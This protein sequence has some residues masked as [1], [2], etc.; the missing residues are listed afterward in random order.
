MPR[1]EATFQRLPPLGVGI[2][3][4]LR[5]LATAY[6]LTDWPG[7]VYQANICA[8]IA[9]WTGSICTRLASR[10]RSASEFIP[11]RL[12]MHTEPSES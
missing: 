4:S 9:A 5:R 3:A 10:G 7:A 2:W 1:I 12:H 6:K 11:L 8:T